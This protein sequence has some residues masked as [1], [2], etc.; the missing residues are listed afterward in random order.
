MANLLLP[1]T[2]YEKVLRHCITGSC[3]TE[4]CIA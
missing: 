4:R 1:N 2:T 3:M